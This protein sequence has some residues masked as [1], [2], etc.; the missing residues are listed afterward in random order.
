MQSCHLSLFSRFFCALL[1]ILLPAGRVKAQSQSSPWKQVQE[2]LKAE[3]PKQGFYPKENSAFGSIRYTLLGQF[4]YG[5]QDGRVSLRLPL[6]VDKPDKG[7]DWTAVVRSGEITKEY[8]E[9]PV[10]LSRRRLGPNQTVRSEVEKVANRIGYLTKP[11]REWKEDV[12]RNNH[13]Y[14]RETL[15]GPFA[16]QRHDVTYHECPGFRMQLYAKYD[17]FELQGVY[18]SRT[19]SLYDI[20]R[21]VRRPTTMA[22]FAGFEFTVSENERYCILCEVPERTNIHGEIPYASRI[23]VDNLLTTIAKTLADVFGKDPVLDREIGKSEFERLRSNVAKKSEYGAND[24]IRA[25]LKNGVIGKVLVKTG[26]VIRD[27][28]YGPPY[29]VGKGDQIKIGDWVRTGENGRVRIELCDRDEERNAGPTVI[30]MGRNSELFF[31][32]FFVNF[33]DPPVSRSLFSLLKGMVRM[34]FYGD[35]IDH[36]FSV[37]AGVAVCGGRGTDMIIDYEPDN[38]QVNAYIIDGF[39]DVTNT[40]TG[41]ERTLAANQQLTV[42]KGTLGQVTSM[43]REVWDGIVSRQGLDTGGGELPAADLAE[44]ECSIRLDPDSKIVHTAGTR[45]I[46]LSVSGTAPDLAENR[47][48]YKVRALFSRDGAPLTDHDGIYCTAEGKVTNQIWLKQKHVVIEGNLFSVTFHTPLND[49]DLTA[50]DDLSLTIHV[51]LLKNNRVVSEAEPVPLT[52]DKHLVP[53]VW[54]SNV[55]VSSEVTGPGQYAIRAQSD[56]SVNQLNQGAVRFEMTVMTDTFKKIAVN[57]RQYRMGDGCA[58]AARTLSGDAA[59][60]ID[61]IDLNLPQQVLRLS[62]GKHTLNVHLRALNAE[63]RVVGISRP[64]PVTVT[65]SDDQSGYDIP[66]IRAD[67]AGVRFYE[68]G[69]ETLPFGKRKYASRFA[70]SSARRI[71]WEVELEHTKPGRNIDVTI[72]SAWYRPDGSSYGM[73]T[74]NCTI[75][76]GWNGSFHTDN[77]GWDEPGHWKPGKYR[78]DLTI[79]GEGIATGYFEIVR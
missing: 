26:E 33:S 71:C 23:A 53:R 38:R 27:P 47:N 78:V 28:G 16:W 72:E 49:L 57:D 60:R 8:S 35:G 39:M 37:K 12:I 20:H 55:D 29:E 4:Y 44:E 34:L 24:H 69:H 10:V 73:Y 6:W 17:I 43:S 45:T 42:N 25:L 1:F 2:I 56:V 40:K 63:G 76:S 48:T 7:E 9:Y 11:D 79:A 13:L 51:M 65:L 31:E 18:K 61:H 66:S 52:I 22:I 36:S 64:Y 46:K 77:L 5:D 15:T 21:K 32:T 67:V 30:N 75:Q 74:K 54:F 59:V 70:A 19:N 58:G 41:E 50:N 62:A 68:R 14:S 3:F